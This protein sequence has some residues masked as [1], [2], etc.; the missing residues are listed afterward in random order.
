MVSAELESKAKVEAVLDNPSD[1][2]AVGEA[3]HKAFD[4]ID[5]W[6]QEIIP[7]W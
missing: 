6:M 5:T 2:K 7:V 4:A 1:P 3:V